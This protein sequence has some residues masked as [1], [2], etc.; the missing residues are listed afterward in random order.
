MNGPNAGGGQ[1][2][3]TKVKKK[4]R[5]SRGDGR[6]NKAATKLPYTRILAVLLLSTNKKIPGK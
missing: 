6:N 1:G 3:R 2:R 5:I 4:Q